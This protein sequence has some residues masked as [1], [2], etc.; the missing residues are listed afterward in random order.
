MTDPRLLPVGTVT[1]FGVLAEQTLTG[2]FTT[3]GRFVPFVKLAPPAPV[4]PLIAGITA[5]HV[6]L[7]EA[8]RPLMPE[9]RT[10]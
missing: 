4:T 6:A 9:R 3:D 10:W 7:A 2:W 8:M 5:D 1:D